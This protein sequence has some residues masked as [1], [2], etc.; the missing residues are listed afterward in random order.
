MI[1]RRKKTSLTKIAAISLF[2]VLLLVVLNLSSASIRNLCYKIIS[3][4]QRPFWA[5]GS[6][7][8]N[9]FYSGSLKNER[10]TLLAENQRLLYQ[11]SVLQDLRAENESLRMALNLNLQKDFNLVL[12]NIIGKD[13]L[14]D[15]IYID[16]GSADGLLINMPVI[17]E[18]R[19]I[20]GKVS[21]VYKNYSKVSLITDDNFVSDVRI[22]GKDIFG[23]AKGY[24]NNV[25]KLDLVPKEAEITEGDVLVTSSLEGIF[26]KDLSLGT[27]SEITKEDTK[28]YQTAKINHFFSLNT[29]DELFVIVN[30]KNK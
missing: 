3:P 26:P 9:L 19:V 17:N 13:S 18:E 10:D 7:F 11:L 6:S 16:K 15:A 23:V 22:Q 5:I 2:I 8:S 4:I 28:P 29:A 20:F 27:I 24:G 25:L 1:A 30:F 14:N 12:A 21:E